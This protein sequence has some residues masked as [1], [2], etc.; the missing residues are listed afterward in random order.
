M[1]AR[2]DLHPWRLVP[3]P[4]KRPARAWREPDGSIALEAEGAV[5]FLVRPLLPEEA[6]APVLAWSWRVDEAPPPTDLATRGG[7]DRPA[8]LHLAYASSGLGGLLARGLGDALGLGPLSGRLMTYAWGGIAPSGTV[9]ATPGGGGRA[10]LRVQRGPEAPLRTWLEEVAEP[11]AEFLLAFRTA[12]PAPTHLLLS[13]D[14]DDRGGRALARFRDPA[15][16]AA[17]PQRQPMRRP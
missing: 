16:L 1:T 8:A 17:R 15:F 11:A 4:G 14:T 7:D 5:G 12:P 3:V 10:M 13:A 6:A 2:S 9:L